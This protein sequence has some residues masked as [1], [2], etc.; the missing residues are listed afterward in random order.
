MNKIVDAETI[1]SAVPLEK[2]APQKMTR[3][4]KLMHLASIVRKRATVHMYHG[5]EYYREDA[6]DSVIDG[7]GGIGIFGLAASDPILREQGFEGDG[8]GR[9]S[10]RQVMNFFELT[11]EELHEFSCNCGGERTSAQIA[12]RIERLAGRPRTPSPVIDRPAP[13]LVG[14]MRAAFG[15]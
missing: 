5:L 10:L 11:Q 3:T 1:L 8:R 7:V 9:I 13:S 14:R 6:L 4:E 2:P 12:N 15:I